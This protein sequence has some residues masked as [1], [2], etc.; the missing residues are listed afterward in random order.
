MENN[1]TN[2]IVQSQLGN[3][4]ALEQLLK[5]IQSRI[6]N[7]IYRFK[8]D[9]IDIN[10]I[11]QNVSIKVG[12]K[13]KQLKNPKQ[14]NQW[15]KKIVVNSCNDYFR[16]TR[17]EKEEIRLD[18]VDNSFISLIPDDTSNPQELTLNNELNYIIRTS[19]K[20]L[21]THYK[22]P[23][24]LREIDGLTYEEISN[25]T[26]STIGTVKSRIARAR[27]KIK[28]ELDKYRKE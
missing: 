21:P 1:E 28:D 23:I 19:I 25:L 7:S 10:D 8:N 15:L 16:K 9:E 2:L 3:K 27:A 14:F 24:K 13:I 12:A 11:A 26:N 18:S 6:Y 17:K 5:R 4:T 20:N 22:I